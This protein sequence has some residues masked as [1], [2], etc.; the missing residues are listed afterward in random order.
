[1]YAIFKINIE[2]LETYNRK[3]S[4]NTSERLYC[5]CIKKII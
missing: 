1:M 3:I 5:D 4:K 2:K